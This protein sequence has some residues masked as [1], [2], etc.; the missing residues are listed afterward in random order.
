[1]SRQGELLPDTHALVADPGYSWTEEF[2]RVG[3]YSALLTRLNEVL[4]VEW[5]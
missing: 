1:M 5:R 2:C 3:G 4:E